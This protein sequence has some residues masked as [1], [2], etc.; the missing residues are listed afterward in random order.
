MLV[1]TVSV[2]GRA[3]PFAD[4]VLTFIPT[5]Y[6]PQNWDAADAPSTQIKEGC[7]TLLWAYLRDY[8]HEN[9]TSQFSAGGRSV[10]V[11]SQT[12]KVALTA[13]APDIFLQWIYFSFFGILVVVPLVAKFGSTLPLLV[14]QAS[15]TS[16]WK[17]HLCE[18]VKKRS[19][20]ATANR[21]NQAVLRVYMYES[22]W[23]KSELKYE[24]LERHTKINMQLTIKNC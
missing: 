22:L 19:H 21:T 16:V 3:R 4:F 2:F 11:S 9:T 18:N 24:K 6:Q 13:W 5:L 23:L 10:I 20:V 8:Q 12:S 17:L 7:V 14:L 1:C 15:D